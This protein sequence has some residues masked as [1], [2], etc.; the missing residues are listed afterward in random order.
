MHWSN[1][2]KIDVKL[3]QVENYRNLP[4]SELFKRLKEFSI[5]LDKATFIFYAEELDSP[6]DFTDYL[7]ADRCLKTECEDRIYLT[8]FELWRR[9]KT[10]KPSLSVIC[11]ELD[12][13]IYLYD[14]DLLTNPTSLQN[15]IANFL[16]VLEENVDAGISPLET[17][18][19]ISAYCANDIETFLYD[20]ITEQI[21]G[22]D[23]SYAQELIDDF[24]PYF[25]GDKW[26]AFLRIKLLAYF[27]TKVAYP[28]FSELIEEHIQEDDLEFNLEVLSFI[29]KMG[30]PH[31]FNQVVRQ[32][33]PLLR[34]EEGFHD[35]LT[36]CLEYYQRLDQEGQ[37]Q[38]IQQLIAKRSHILFET[39]FNPN[40]QDMVAFLNLLRS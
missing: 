16:S 11:D 18:E 26:F 19:Y 24:G 36:I 27:N 29:A 20:F 15:A 32:T 23:E 35:L 28:D 4:L 2:A 30:S 5:H 33:I 13:Q 34:K 3:W 22:E 7:I 1:D 9:L 25:K 10:E 39:P 8:V 37:E 14:N 31:Q 38:F 12:H 21:E 6:E 40:D 17:L